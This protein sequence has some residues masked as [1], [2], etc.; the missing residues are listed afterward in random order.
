MLDNIPIST[1]LASG[2][3]AISLFGLMSGIAGV[4]MLL[5][6]EAEVN[7]ITD[8]AGPVVETTDDVIYSVVQAHKITVEILADEDVENIQRRVTEFDEASDMFIESY[9]AL[10]ALI[11]EPDMQAQLDLAAA[12]RVELLDAVQTMRDAHA[13]ELAEEAEARRLAVEFDLTGDVLLRELEALATANEIEM[14]N[15]EDEGDRLV[16]TGNASASRIND[17]LGMV[18]EQ[19]YP[20]VEESK[21]LQI[22]VEELEGTATRYLGEEDANAL[23]AIRDEFIAL[24]QS[25][26]V[27]FE[28]LLELAE[29][30]QD[31]ATIEN[32][33]NIFTTWVAQAQEP[34]QIFDTHN[35][36]LIAETE[37]DVAAELVDD[38]ADQL[39]AELNVIAD[40]GDAISS[41]T[42][43][44]AAAQ[45]RT[46]LF[47]VGGLALIILVVS[48]V[49]FLMVRQTIMA[50]LIHIIGSLN[51]LAD[52]QLDIETAKNERKDEIGQL[53]NA[54]SV[55]HAQAVEKNRLAEE[56]EATKA[57]AER[58]A[59]TLQSLFSSFETTIGNVVNTVSGAAESLQSSSQKMTEIAEQT[60]ERSSIVASASE[61]AS[62]N[63]QSV[64]TAAEEISASVAEIGRQAS[65]SSTKAANAE[66]EAE[67]T[68]AKVET[69]SSA[70]QRIGDVVTLI[71][72]IAEQTNLLA[73]NATIEAARAGEAGK[74]FAV[75]ASEVKNLASQTAKATAD[76][77]AQVTEIQEATQTSATAISDISKSIQD[78]S[79][80]SSSIASAV[81]EQAAATQEIAG[82]VHRAASGTQ[83]VTTNIATVSTSAQE[84]QTSAN[85]VLGSADELADQ[86]ELL[87]REVAGF[88]ENV[89]SAA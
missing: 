52:G 66:R 13:T 77:S 16:A 3:A 15:A 64:A 51:A 39:V 72:D 76:I 28:H 59:T 53:N 8:Y 45:V 1:K 61:E 25:A 21:N 29:T 27:R 6:I 2:I 20:A 82:N 71:Q 24:A 55:F 43:E 48:V 36:M 40:R 67:S 54:L 58:K 69:L 46:A 56:Q 30:P 7:E 34:E 68:M 81:E 88:V 18:F 78:L 57:E 38:F 10:D 80:I 65:D 47:V 89:R 19:D 83:D 33:R 87:R 17:L 31:V 60:S 4:F 41:S 23:P 9:A 86:A 75:V 32:I 14:Q 5:N 73:L 70:A 84:S 62:T 37:A 79:E 50:P 44:Q 85:A 22:T 63:V 49:L 42:D 74:G 12:T 26:T 35:D 11:V